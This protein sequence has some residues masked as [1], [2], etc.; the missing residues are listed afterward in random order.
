MM[1]L[2]V[3]LPLLG[4]AAL[5][6]LPVYAFGIT[7]LSIV[8]NRKNENILRCAQTILPTIECL[9]SKQNYFLPAF[10]KKTTTLYDQ[11]MLKIKE[12][13][14]FTP[15]EI[16]TDYEDVLFSFIISELSKCQSCR[17]YVPS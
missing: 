14:P 11:V 16:L 2:L 6:G 10:P 12:I 1:P 3:E 15:T 17:L 7:L 5:G 4:G 9:S 8:L 13:L